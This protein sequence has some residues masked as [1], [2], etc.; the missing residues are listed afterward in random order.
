M[1]NPLWHTVYVS[2]ADVLWQFGGRACNGLFQYRGRRA[3]R[4]RYPDMEAACCRLVCAC[5]GGS[6]DKGVKYYLRL[7]DKMDRNYRF[8]RQ[9]M[10]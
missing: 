6:A 4:R 2:A 10:L 5:Y 1:W 7:I 9:Y 8:S 3:D